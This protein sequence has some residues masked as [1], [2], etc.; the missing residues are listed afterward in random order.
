MKGLAY[1]DREFTGHHVI[2][3]L[4]DT[5]VENALAVVIAY[6][7]ATYYERDVKHGQYIF[8]FII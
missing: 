1:K 2:F 7:R 3:P 4:A 5:Y 8:L 6:D